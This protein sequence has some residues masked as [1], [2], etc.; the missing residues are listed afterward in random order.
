MA[1]TSACSS[2][3]RLPWALSP[4][5]GDLWME[6]VVPGEASFVSKVSVIGTLA[7]CPVKKR[8]E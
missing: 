3:W 4:L 7:R 6:R 1:Q 2:S 5:R 8:R